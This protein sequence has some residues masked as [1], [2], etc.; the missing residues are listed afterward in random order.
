MKILT[1]LQARTSSTRLPGKVLKDLLGQ[2]MI[3]HQIQRV[4]RARAIGTLCLVTSTD[5]SDDLLVE[6][7]GQ[8][9][10][11]VFRGSLDDV[12]DRFYQAASL[13]APDVVVRLTGDCPLIDP[14]IIDQALE[15]FQQEGCDYLSNSNPATYPDGMDVEVFSFHALEKAWECATLPSEREHVTAYIYKHPEQFK[16]SNLINDIDLSSIRLTVDEVEDFHLVEKI[17][18]ELLPKNP[19]F[20]L[21]DVLKLLQQNP[22][23]VSLNQSISRNAGYQR[24]ILQDA[25]INNRVQ[26]NE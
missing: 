25:L 26:E 8:A 17:Y 13:H 21:T 2:P 1:L 11:M 3:L 14:Q 16:L 5:T 9:D 24:S 6:T 19:E 15:R 22:Q 20:L 18:G 4:Q 7:V 10:V 12:L 23:W